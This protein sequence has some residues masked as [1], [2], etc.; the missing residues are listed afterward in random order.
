MEKFKILQEL[1]K[2]DIEIQTEK[3]L[4]EKQKTVPIDFLDTGMPRNLQFVGG[5]KKNLQ[6]TIKQGMPVVRKKPKV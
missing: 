2:C 3:M 5:K 4:L 1:L 6:S